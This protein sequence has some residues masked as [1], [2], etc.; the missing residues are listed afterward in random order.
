MRERSSGNGERLGA[1]KLAPDLAQE[2]PVE[3]D[4]RGKSAA[5]SDLV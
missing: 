5:E 2:R 3:L 4:T 1:A